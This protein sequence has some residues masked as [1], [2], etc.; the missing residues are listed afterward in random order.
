MGSSWDVGTVE[1]VSP[2]LLIKTVMKKGRG[3]YK[4]Y[5][6]EQLQ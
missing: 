5:T 3:D 2:L 4:S 1:E 6:W